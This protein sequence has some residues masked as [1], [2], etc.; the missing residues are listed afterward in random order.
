MMTVQFGVTLT[1]EVLVDSG[2]LKV[3]LEEYTIKLGLDY[4]QSGDF[5]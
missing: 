1:V 4:S 2:H 3:V 5:L